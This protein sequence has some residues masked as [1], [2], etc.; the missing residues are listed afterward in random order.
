M[1]IDPLLQHVLAGAIAALLAHAAWHKWHAG[2]RFE[3]QMA[4]YRLLPERLVPP[5]ARILM[6]LE[7][8]LA[9]ALVVP[10]TR[11]PAALV[12]AMLLAA[13]AIAMAINLARGRRHID[14]G[15]GDTP[16]LLTPWLVLRNAILVGAAL[17]TALP[18]APRAPATL[19][20]VLG[21]IGFSALV[22]AWLTLE[23]L[24]TNASTLREW[25][26]ARE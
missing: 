18:A 12:A 25:R 11:E 13:Y 21:I 15:C 3:A 8:T 16:Q 14:C 6:V 2:L 24:L 20:L 26:E 4:E 23:Q 17:V 19:D 9:V 7:A 10:F 22:L 5:G 1:M